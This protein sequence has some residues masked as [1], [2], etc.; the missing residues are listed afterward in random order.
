MKGLRKRWREIPCAVHALKAMSF[1]AVVEKISTWR[2][3]GLSFLGPSVEGL[4][5]VFKHYL[6]DSPETYVEQA[7]L[8]KGAPA[9]YIRV[10]VSAMSEAA[11][12]IKSHDLRHLL[13]LCASVI[14]H[15][16]HENTAIT[17][18]PQGLEDVD[19]Q[20][21]RNSISELISA[22]CTSKV[23]ISY[24]RNIW[25]VLHPLTN[26]TARSN[27][28]DSS[29]VDIR[30]RDFALLSIN[31]PCGKAMHAVFAYVRWVASTHE[32]VVEGK[33]VIEGGFATLP[34]VKELLEC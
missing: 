19:W 11:E 30:V 23:P 32:K 2:S 16:I 9:I 27:V 24:R 15:P 31:S 34:E 4:A 12:K 25:E 18:D 21:T 3:K 10:F 29:E 20:W 17:D 26:D 14:E 7:E 5:E 22:M 1:S 6:L 28:L 8:L 33:K 13:N